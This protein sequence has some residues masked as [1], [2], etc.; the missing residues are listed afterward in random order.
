MTPP[1]YAPSSKTP[2]CTRRARFRAALVSQVYSPPSDSDVG[3][4]RP[5]EFRLTND[6]SALRAV[7]QD[8]NVHASGPTLLDVVVPHLRDAAAKAHQIWLP[9]LEPRVGLGAIMSSPPRPSARGTLSVPIG[10]VDKPA[11]QKR[12]VLVA[13]LSGAAGHLLVVGASLTGKTTLLRTLVAS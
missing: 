6:A 4:P 1:L 13:D 2:T 12:D 9:P 8:P 11:E 5:R 3:A 7:V 10:L